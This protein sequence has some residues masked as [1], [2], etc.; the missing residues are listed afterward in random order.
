M[1]I[2]SAVVWLA[3][4]LVTGCVEPEE[5]FGSIE[6]TVLRD[7]PPVPAPGASVALVGTAWTLAANPAGVALFPMASTGK[8]R[9]T[10][11]LQG[12]CASSDSVDVT[13][14]ARST[15]TITLGNLPCPSDRVT[16]GGGD[17]FYSLVDVRTFGG[18]DTTCE[19]DRVVEGIA[20][21]GDLGVNALSLRRTCHNAAWVFTENHT[22]WFTN[23][24]D[25]I[26][27]TNFEGDLLNVS[28]PVNRLR[29]PVTIWIADSLIDADYGNSILPVD[30][31]QANGFFHDTRSGLRLTNGLIA[32]DPPD[33]IDVGSHVGPGAREAT[34]GIIG[35][36]CANTPSIIA[37]PQVY[38]SD[39]I[40]IY[41]LSAIQGGFGRTCRE[42]GAANVI[43]LDKDA[44]YVTLVHEIGHALGLARPFSGHVDTVEGMHPENVMW[45]APTVAGHLSLGQIARMHMDVLSWLN[46][47]MP[48]GTVRSQ[49]SILA[50][51]P[52]E[53]SCPGS[54]ATN[55]CP[56]IDA[57][58]PRALPAN[59]PPGMAP[60]CFVTVEPTCLSLAVGATGTVTARGWT[61]IAA[62]D[63]GA[64]DQLVAS[65]SPD[66]ARVT[67]GG[68]HPGFVQADIT[69]NAV[70]G[71]TGVLVSIGGNIISVPVRIGS[72]CP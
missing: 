31:D 9:V 36:G 51:L 59:G 23:S 40:N 71:N 52:S 22:P 30:L 57:D 48:L 11:F 7:S 17:A 21:V 43:F 32:D 50:P 18:V 46:Q 35:N 63:S 33:I 69:A 26:P 27:W 44:D 37:S 29:V 16:T 14:G 68:A 53:C 6:V 62:T 58:I 15:L 34:Y 39:H 54:S 67:I 28:L 60:A 19:N 65:L 13:Q 3:F 41:V 70:P 20:G 25:D 5:P 49:Q 56:R 8:G 61:T 1:R 12:Y 55:D 38:R 2:R 72:P 4:V 64:G 47:P 42:Y 24:R 10:A 66:L 45:P